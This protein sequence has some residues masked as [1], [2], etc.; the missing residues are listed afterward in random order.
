MNQS[1]LKHDPIRNYFISVF[2]NMVRQ[3]ITC[4]NAAV[5]VVNPGSLL[6]RNHAGLYFQLFDYTRNCI[7][8]G[9]GLHF[10][11][12]DFGHLKKLWFLRLTK[13]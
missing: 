7:T 4:C 8:G 1:A 5:R 9:E 13:N 6:P 10:I 12:Q 11:I 3:F 2:S